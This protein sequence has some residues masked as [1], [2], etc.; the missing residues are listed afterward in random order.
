[1]RYFMPILG[2]WTEVEEVPKETG[3]LGW[4]VFR[5]GP[6]N[7]MRAVCRYFR[8]LASMKPEVVSTPELRINVSVPHRLRTDC[9]T[10]DDHLH[11][12]SWLHDASHVGE[13]FV[14][15]KRMLVFASGCGKGCPFGGCTRPCILTSFTTRVGPSNL[16]PGFLASIRCQYEGKP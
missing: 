16:E 5:S 15:I 14:K 13:P 1:M 11:T 12:T 10:R 6:Y 8:L 2:E 7:R 4:N 3:G 9:E